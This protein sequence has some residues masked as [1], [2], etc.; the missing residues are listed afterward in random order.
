[1]HQ[2][3]QPKSLKL[4]GKGRWTIHL[5]SNTPLTCRLPQAKYMGIGVGILINVLVKT[6]T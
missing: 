6:R 5:Y 3:I 2:P 4:I 1:M